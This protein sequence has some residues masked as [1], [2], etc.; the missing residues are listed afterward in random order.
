MPSEPPKSYD[1][2]VR[3]TVPEPETSWRPSEEQVRQ[4]Y[5]G[6]RALDP[7]EQKLFDRVRDAL[8][9]GG[10][11]TTLVTIEIDHDRV[12]LRGEV[13]AGSDL[14]QIERI[15]CSVDGVSELVDWL[16]IEAD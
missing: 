15:V 4:A 10:V 5:T 12:T 7:E 1:E 8:F 2:I 11:D 3:R 13:A 14:A 16:V 6:F 9:A